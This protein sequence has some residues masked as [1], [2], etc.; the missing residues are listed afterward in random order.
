MLRSTTTGFGLVAI[1]LHW[2]IALLVFVM[3][4]L[5]NIMGALVSTDPLRSVLLDLHKLTG[6]TILALVLLRIV[7]RLAN[8]VPMLPISMKS[9]QRICARLSHYALYGLT[10]LIPLTGWALVSARVQTP[11]LMLF[12][13]LPVPALPVLQYFESGAKAVVLFWQV[14]DVLGGL[15]VLLVL[16]HIAA[17]MRHHFVLSDDVLRRMMT[18]RLAGKADSRDIGTA[19]CVVTATGGKK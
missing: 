7:W 11:T 19:H 10:V 3:L 1:I 18:A 17:A 8:P 13:W 9:W 16:I 15:L 5:G 14:H 12:D 4:A 6:L 2:V